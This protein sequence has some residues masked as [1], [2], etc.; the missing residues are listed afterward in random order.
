M[1]L[2]GAACGTGRQTDVSRWRCA[3]TSAMSRRGIATTRRGGEPGAAAPGIVI[4]MSPSSESTA[5]VFPG[6]WERRASSAASSVRSTSCGACAEGSRFAKRP[7]AL[8]AAL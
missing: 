3:A 1:G 7:C 6:S 2:A 5:R 4:R 8:A